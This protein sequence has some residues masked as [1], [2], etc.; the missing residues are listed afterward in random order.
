LPFLGCFPLGPMFASA[1]KTEP[2]RSESS[3]GYGK[4]LCSF[5]SFAADTDLPLR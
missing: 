3:Q 1:S 4:S 2:Q 5:Q